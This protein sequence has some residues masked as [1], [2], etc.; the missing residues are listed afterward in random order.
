MLS[1]DFI[2]INDVDEDI[3][4]SLDLMRKINVKWW[5]QFRETQAC[6]QVV[7]TWLQ[8]HQAP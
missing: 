2:I 1:W 5:T 6:S 3:G 4:Y 7:H 8:S